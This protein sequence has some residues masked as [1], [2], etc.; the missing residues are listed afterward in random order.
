MSKVNK[1]RNLGLLILAG[2]LAISVSM[3]GAFMSGIFDGFHPWRA[4]SFI[5]GFIAFLALPT[6]IAYGTWTPNTRAV[7]VWMFFL[8]AAN[9]LMEYGACADVRMWGHQCPN[10]SLLGQATAA[11]LRPSSWL[12]V[13]IGAVCQI[14]SALSTRA[15]RKT[16]LVV[17]PKG[18]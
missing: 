9:A 18:I 15:T 8:V 1:T 4:N 13:G 16:N 2:L 14:E 12:A 6:V 10:E 3:N 7:W 11:L 5:F 17:A